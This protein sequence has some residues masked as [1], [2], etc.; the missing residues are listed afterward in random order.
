MPRST[1]AYPFEAK[2][3][4]P[5][6]QIAD[7][8]GSPRAKHTFGLTLGPAGGVSSL[9]FDPP[10]DGWFT[11][12]D[13]L[14]SQHTPFVFFDPFDAPEYTFIRWANIEQA[15]MERLLG[16]RFEAGDFTP[17]HASPPR[18]LPVPGQLPATWDV[19]F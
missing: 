4:S 10:A 3:F 9:T 15:T 17:W 7:R 2:V 16:L 6:E 19:M 14:A 18:Q 12:L 1:Q 8:F 5:L 13:L 11:R